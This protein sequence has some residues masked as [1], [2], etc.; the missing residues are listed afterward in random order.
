MD[1]STQKMQQK[2]MLGQWTTPSYPI[3]AR[4]SVLRPPYLL[5]VR[6]YEVPLSLIL[7]F[8]IL[9]LSDGLQHEPPRLLKRVLGGGELWA[10][11]LEQGGEEGGRQPGHLGGLQNTFF[12]KERKLLFC[13]GEKRA[14]FGFFFHLSMA[15]TSPVSLSSS[16]SR[17]S[18][19]SST[20]QFDT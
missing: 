10:E 6:V 19:V 9:V 4:I 18:P 15:L 5:Q 2:I 11:P 3:E 7:L 13:C 17:L 1:K 8:R 16:K 14:F 20:L 12:K